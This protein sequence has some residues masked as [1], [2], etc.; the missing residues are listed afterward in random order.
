MLSVESFVYCLP[1]RDRNPHGWRSDILNN[2]VSINVYVWKDSYVTCREGSTLYRW[3]ARERLIA[4]Q[5]KNT[6]LYILTGLLAPASLTS[7][8]IR[9]AV[10]TL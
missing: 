2:E 10:P 4:A 8:T 9:H 6:P 3:Y 5:R 7:P 1:I